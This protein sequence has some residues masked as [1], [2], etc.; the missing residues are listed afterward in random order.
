MVK[1]E[2]EKETK[3]CQKIQ[4]MN[5]LLQQIWISPIKFSSS[6]YIDHFDQHIYF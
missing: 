2:T 3:L 1:A 4:N 6:H 5:D